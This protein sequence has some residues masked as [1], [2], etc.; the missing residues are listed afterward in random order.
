MNFFPF[1]IPSITMNMSNI[2]TK[3]SIN[4]IFYLFLNLFICFRVFVCT[5]VTVLFA[6]NAD[7]QT[8]C[9][10]IIMINICFRVLECTVVTAL[11]ATNAGFAYLLSWVI[12]HNQFVGIRVRQIDNRQIDTKVLVVYTFPHKNIQKFAT[13]AGNI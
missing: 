4:L 7:K 6:T 5:V 8:S 2:I 3:S 10:F 13:N 1:I 12:L 11:F 9:Y